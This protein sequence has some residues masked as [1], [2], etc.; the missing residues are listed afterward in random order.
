MSKEKW[1]M[2]YFRYAT[3]CYLAYAAPYSPSLHIVAYNPTTT[4]LGSR[5]FST[6]AGAGRGDVTGLAARVTGLALLLR[7][8][9]RDVTVLTTVLGR[10]VR[11]IFSA[12]RKKKHSRSTFGG[13][14]SHHRNREK[15]QRGTPWK[16]GQH[17]RRSKARL[18]SKSIFWMKVDELT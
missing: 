18:F 11:F 5:G 16:C 2:R 6:S 3:F 14:R 15:H 10:E 9:P 17:H 12:R 13:H 7:A 8:F 4:S 1:E